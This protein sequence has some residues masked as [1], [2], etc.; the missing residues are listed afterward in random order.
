[1]PEP[2]STTAAIVVPAAMA[3]PLITVFGVATGLRADVLLAGFIGSII[4]MG[5][6]NT[7]PGTG[8]TARDLLRTSIRR[9]VVAVCSSGFAGYLAPFGQELLQLSVPGMLGLA[10]VLGG[11]AQ[12]LLPALIEAARRR[13]AGGPSTT[14]HNP[15]KE[16][17]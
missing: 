16:A 1:M 5:L 11:G 4:A 10:A 14:S 17:S 15:T 2:T 13:V 3:A 12:T 8:D 6:L 7:V 9:V